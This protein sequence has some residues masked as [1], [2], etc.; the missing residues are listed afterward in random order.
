MF[1]QP[2]A[3]IGN[4]AIDMSGAVKVMGIINASPESFYKRSV[5]KT[6]GE[7]AEAALQM[8]SAG[9]ALIDIGGMSTAPYLETV[10]SAADEASRIKTAVSAAIESGCSLPI[11]ADTPRASVAQ[12][13]IDAGALAINDVTGLKF[14]TKMADVV[15]SAGVSVIVGAYEPLGYTCGGKYSST[16]AAIRR[17][18][19]IAKA[20]GIRRS[21]IV[22]DPSIG[23]FRSEGKNPFFTRMVEMPWYLR[24]IDVLSNL[25]KLAA[26]AP[27]CV[28][29]SAKSFLGHLLGIDR[30]DD[31]LIPS[32]AC[33]FYAAMKGARIIRTHNVKESVQALSMFEVLEG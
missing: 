25:E 12:S 16:L 17:S 27:V 28:S 6:K 5:K 15:A 18:I 29:V 2:L 33:E 10:V 4:V 31:R 32:L 9:A 14:D 20:A 22:V 26:I 19:T 24:D 8:E 21:R 30:A 23:F 3:K 1:L 11:S 7:I 13:A